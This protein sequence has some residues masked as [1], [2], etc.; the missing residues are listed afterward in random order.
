VRMLGGGCEDIVVLGCEPAD[1]G[2]E[3]GEE[4]RMGLSPVVGAVVD[5]AADMVETLIAQ[6]MERL[7]LRTV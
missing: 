7:S 6:T 3:H 5:Q 2:F 1:F 4:G